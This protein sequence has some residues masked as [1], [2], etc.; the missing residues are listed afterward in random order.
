MYNSLTLTLS[1]LAVVALLVW[2]LRSKLTFSHKSYLSA[3]GLAILATLLVALF[4]RDQPNSWRPIWVYSF[5]ALTG[6]IAL[7]GFMEYG[8]LRLFSLFRLGALVR[9][10]YYEVLLQPFTLII[11]ALTIVMLILCAYIPYYTFNEDNKMFRDVATQFVL[12]AGLA[13]TIYAAAKVV[14]EEIE[15]RTMLTLMSKPIS[16]QEVLI[17]K[18]LGI[19]CVI[20]TVLGILSLATMT[21]SSLHWLSDRSMD[22]NM[23][24]NPRE[25]ASLKLETHKNT[26]ALF[27][28]FL[29]QF[30]ELATLAAIAVAIS[31]RHSLA[32]NITIIVL[33][34][35]VA[36]LAGYL[37]M[38]AIKEPWHSIVSYGSY[39]LPSLSNFDIS[40]RLI[41]GQYALSVTEQQQDLTQFGQSIPPTYALIWGYTGLVAVYSLF[42]IGAALSLATVLFRTRELT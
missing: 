17:G 36:N 9:V 7:I 16:R 11:M 1:S 22:V 3:L 15:T 37:P 4:Y 23:A 27:P 6:A 26:L 14:D 32:M 33:I 13:I 2:A 20:A 41:Y 25:M 30:M 24:V 5:A 19:L 35:I 12:M 42:Y 39:L 8:I 40:Q 10:T 34:Y 28:L 21:T 31:T 18:Y 38:L 29:L